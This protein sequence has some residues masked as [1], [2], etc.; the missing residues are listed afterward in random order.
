MRSDRANMPT[1]N[2]N[3][4]QIRGR[5]MTVRRVGIARLLPLLAALGLLIR[6]STVGAQNQPL[7]NQEAFLSETRTR[8][9]TDSTLQSSYVYV[10][11][12]REMKL[13]K[14]GSTR[15]ESVRVVE[16]YP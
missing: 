12:R 13:D 16:S 5:A 7:P 15:E 2:T 10:E 8:L 1:E 11:T 4:G 9:Q 14:S 3:P 6:G